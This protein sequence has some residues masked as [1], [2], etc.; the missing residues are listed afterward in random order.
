MSRI[1]LSAVRRPGHAL[2]TLL[3]IL[4]GIFY[5]VYYPLTGHRFVAGR[6]LR[7]FGRL[8][9]SGPGRVVFGQN[10]VVGM[11]V[12]PFTHEK[13]AAIIVGDNVFLNGTRF[14][15]CEL[16][17]VGA[18][19]ILGECRVI[20]SNFHSVAKDRRT[21]TAHVHSAPVRIG[22]NTW[23]CPDA[24]LLPGCVVGENS[25]VAIAAVAR[26]ELLRDSIYAGNPAVK[27]ADVGDH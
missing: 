24:V 8:K 14:G 12:T 13:S 5:R 17:T 22:P 25:V 7:V 15:S 11:T 6:N 27:V 2:S 3:A 18:G 19:A 9:I 20:D 21:S 1:L 10:V 23:I 26:G 16:I 4:R